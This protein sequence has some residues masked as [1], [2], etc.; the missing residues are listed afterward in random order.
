MKA[1]S[2]VVIITNVEG[3]VDQV[4]G[5]KR[6]LLSPKTTRS[7][8]IRSTYQGMPPILLLTLTGH[9]SMAISMYS[10]RI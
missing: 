9:H 1:A 5:R 4:G 3:I 8:V 10:V 6:D 7:T 2:F